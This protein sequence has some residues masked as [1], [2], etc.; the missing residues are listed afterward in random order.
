MLVDEACEV[1][2]WVRRP[3]GWE[4]ESGCCSPHTTGATSSQSGSP[5][6]Y[7]ELW[8]NRKLKFGHEFGIFGT[9][10]AGFVEQKQPGGFDTGYCTVMDL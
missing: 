3:A 5:G 9:D 7:N 8:I 6:G 10:I 4:P 1:L 2:G